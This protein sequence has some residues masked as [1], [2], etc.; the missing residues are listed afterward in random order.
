MA[1]PARKRSREPTARQKRFVGL[2]IA[3]KMPVDYGNWL[4]FEKC[5]FFDYKNQQG[6]WSDIK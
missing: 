6:Q 1:G 2:K 4:I 3:C 5:K